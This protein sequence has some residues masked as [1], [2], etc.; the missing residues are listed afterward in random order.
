[1]RTTV[2]GRVRPQRRSKERLG[3]V[4][5]SPDPFPIPGLRRLESDL[6]I[7]RRPG[8]RSS[9]GCGRITRCGTSG[10]CFVGFPDL[11]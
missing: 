11:P 8:R 1:M 7:P 6:Q 4:L 3:V 9:P 2:S 5:E 10:L